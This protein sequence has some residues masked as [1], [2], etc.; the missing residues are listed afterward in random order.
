M[1]VLKVFAVLLL[2]G[3]VVMAC[4]EQNR[5]VGDV[6]QNQGQSQAEPIEQA[7]SDAEPQGQPVKQAMVENQTGPV[8]LAGMVLETE[9]GLSLVTATE[10]YLVAGQDLTDMK[11]RRIRVTGTLSEA[12]GGQVLEV[13]TVIPLE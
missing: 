7:E 5:T 8:E 6:D 12:E 3:L 9:K 1:K 10:T 2:A 13:M 4:S 11:G